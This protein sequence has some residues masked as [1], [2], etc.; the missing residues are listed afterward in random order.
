MSFES[1]LILLFA[2]RTVTGRI[3]ED[4]KMPVRL[5]L[6]GQASKEIEWH[7]KVRLTFPS[8]ETHLY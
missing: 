3:W 4:N 7:C 1:A 6:N 5:I 8:A 2:A